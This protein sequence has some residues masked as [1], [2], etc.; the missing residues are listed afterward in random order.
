MDAHQPT[1]DARQPQQSGRPPAPAHHG[2]GKRLVRLLAPRT[3]S[4]KI[5]VGIIIGAVLLQIGVVLLFWFMALNSRSELAWLRFRAVQRDETSFLGHLG[6]Y[7]LV[8]EGLQFLNILI[9]EGGHMVAGGLGGYW[10]YQCKVGPVLL[11]RGRYGFRL[12]LTR[13]D[14]GRGY[15][16][17]L[18]V[19]GQQAALRRAFFIAGGPLASLALVG[20]NI[21]LGAL[22]WPSTCTGLPL[23]GCY[24]Q[25]LFIWATVNAPDAASWFACFLG[26]SLLVSAIALVGSLVPLTTRRGMQ[27]DGLKLLRMA[28]G[29]PQRER[30]L[31]LP[32][33]L[34]MT[35]RGVRPRDWPADL[36]AGLLELVQRL[37]TDRLLLIYCYTLRLD[38][39]RIQEAGDFLQRIVQTLKKAPTIEVTLVL[40]IAFFEARHRGSTRMARAWLAKTPPITTL[41]NR[42]LRSRAEAAIALLE[43]RLADAQSSCRAGLAT[44][45]QTRALS[46]LE[47][48]TEEE[49]LQ[50]MLAEAQWRQA[51]VEQGENRA[52]L[53]VQPFREYGS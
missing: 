22:L 42:L 41:T 47:L 4:G 27:S 6:L 14:L 48:E 3:L 5:F 13:D 15:V 21:L 12:S 7:L 20:V 2:R 8:L 39:R 46:S 18:P 17:S 35:R 51:N 26:W 40:E 45:A 25:G 1:P 44:V 36:V 33:L 11:T 50:E 23:A 38:Q 30:D 34:G 29:G 37:P 24:L 49:S 19:D 43:G 9:H 32:S 28:R 10:F 31:L 53:A 16:I 52:V